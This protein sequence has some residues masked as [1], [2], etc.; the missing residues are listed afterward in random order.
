MNYGPELLSA[1]IPELR[2]NIGCRLQRIEAGNDWC[3]LTFKNADSIFFTWN[4]ETFG[5]CRINAGDVLKLRRQSVKTPFVLGLQRHFGG[6]SLTDVECITGDRVL[7]MTFQRFVGG[8]VSKESKLVLE[9]MGRMSNALFTDENGVIIEAA[10]HIYPEIN[11]YRSI[12]PGALY[13]PPP[14]LAGELPRSGMTDAELT[15][16]LRA[17]RGIGRPIA[18]EL[19]RLWQ[20]GCK[21]LVRTA[22]FGK[23]K[24]FQHFGTYLTAL[25]AALPGV[26]VYDGSGLDFCRSYI[27]DELNRR[28][29]KNLAAQTLKILER[30]RGRR[31]KHIDDLLSQIKKAENRD[32]YRAAGEAIL[33]NIGKIKEH[34]DL[35]TLSYWDSDGERTLEVKL[36]PALDLQ[37]NAKLYF[38]KYQKFRINVSVIR[39]QIR[40]LQADLDD[41]DGLEANLKRVTSAEKLS[42]LNEQIAQQYNDSRKKNARVRKAKTTPPPHLR[43]TLGNSL[44]LVGM[45]EH[46]NRYVTFQEA[47]PDDLWFH[48]HEFSGSHVILK[49]PPSGAAE[50][51]QAVRAA[52]SLALCYSKC[53]NRSSVIDYTEKKQVRHIQGSGPANV[54]YKRSHTIL[55]GPDDWK[56]IIEHR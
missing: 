25:G 17:P 52:A 21:D 15:A 35:V 23:P 42:E 14:S 7:L 29:L 2:C 56:E 13:T 44:I 19:A 46:G 30:Q 18:N 9:F 32:V 6:G 5:I 54:T 51:K 28:V 36:D 24:I 27:A 47:A 16:F 34:Q 26:E 20:N 55:A 31:T 4:S 48:V 49:N 1:L 40:I 50:R 22:L 37:G 43:F 8:G 33:Q 10:K 38:K 3:V 11:R 39:E 53:S 12:L 41:I 45:N